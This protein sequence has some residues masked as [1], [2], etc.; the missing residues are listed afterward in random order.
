MKP[1]QSGKFRQR[2]QLQALSQTETFDSFGQ[3]IQTWSTV[4][5]YWA[6]VTPL[7]GHELVSA[8]QVKSQASLKI[9]M[10]YQGHVAVSGENR[11]ILN[12]R[13]LGLFDV[14]NIEER[15]RVYDMIAYE[16]QQA[17]PV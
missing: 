7:F 17:G 2:V 13:T 14:R 10:R 12:G 16:I 1:L 8:K 6:E 4:G 11:L 9:R 3:P 5:T 15:N